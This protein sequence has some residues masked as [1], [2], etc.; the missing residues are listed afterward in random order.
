MVQHGPVLFVVQPVGTGTLTVRLSMLSGHG[1]GNP[2]LLVYS[3]M[4]GLL[5]VKGVTTVKG[6]LADTTAPL[7]EQFRPIV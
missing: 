2:W 5:S 7:T 6:A 3:K 4:K 1:D